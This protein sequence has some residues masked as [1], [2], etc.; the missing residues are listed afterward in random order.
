MQVYKCE[1]CG[2][3]VRGQGDLY[4][5]LCGYCKEGRFNV[6][7]DWWDFTSPYDRRVTVVRRPYEEKD[8]SAEE[9]SEQKKGKKKPKKS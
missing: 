7:N 3:E 2:T 1:D 4:R 8:E 5:E 6:V 9:T